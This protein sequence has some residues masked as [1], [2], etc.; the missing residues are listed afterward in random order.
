MKY[1]VRKPKSTVADQDPGGGAKWAFAPPKRHNFN[2]TP[3]DEAWK[4]SMNC[5][6]LPPPQTLSWIR[7]CKS[8][9]NVMIFFASH[10]HVTC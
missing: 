5:Y 3:M 2:I 8:M 10:F 6:G 4:E 7:H 1:L 9:M